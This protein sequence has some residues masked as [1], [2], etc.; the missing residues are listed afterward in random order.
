MLDN[1]ECIFEK[2]GWNQINLSN[3]V[4][5]MNA[6]LPEKAED[7]DEDVEVKHNYVVQ[8]IFDLNMWPEC[9]NVN[10]ETKDVTW[11]MKWYTSETLALVKDTDKEDR[12]KALKSSWEANEPGRADKASASRKRF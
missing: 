12:E 8:A 2:K 6:G 7:G 11:A 1:D 5:R 9:A 4:F 3:F 10:E